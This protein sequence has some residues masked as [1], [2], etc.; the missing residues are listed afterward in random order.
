M[1]MEEDFG[2]YPNYWFTRQEF[3]TN[4]KW[5]LHSWY[6]WQYLVM[7]GKVVLPDQLIKFLSILTRNLHNTITSL[8]FQLIS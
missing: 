3:V 1:Q 4:E 8:Q 2:G 5:S 7:N 6:E